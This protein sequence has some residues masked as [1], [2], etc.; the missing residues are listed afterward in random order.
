MESI[1]EIREGCVTPVQLIKSLPFSR[2]LER[3]KKD[4]IADLGQRDARHQSEWRHRSD[5]V[6]QV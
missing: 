4:Y 3:Y 1:L 5:Y 6:R 2:F